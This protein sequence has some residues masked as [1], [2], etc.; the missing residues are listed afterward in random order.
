MPPVARR[1]SSG[2]A[3]GNS[4]LGLATVTLPA[5]RR[6]GLYA[7]FVLAGYLLGFTL[8]P[9]T[10]RRGDGPSGLLLD[11]GVAAGDDGGP[12]RLPTAAR[13]LFPAQLP[14]RQ[15]PA[16]PQHHS[17]LLREEGDVDL[18][19]EWG[20]AQPPPPPFPA[21]MPPANRTLR[22]DVCNGF[23]NQRLSLLYAVLYTVRLQRALVLPVLVEN[24]LQRSDA[25]ILAT[26]ANQV[27]ATVRANVAP[28]HPKPRLVNLSVTRPA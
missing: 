23:A 10:S 19:L 16:A 6:L 21:S 28:R 24:G 26:E 7:L 17:Q 8:A 11:T 15:L 13:S 27:R 5:A 12:Q 25:N 18:D 2:P 3:G 1:A 22:F 20:L 9:G 14:R 4:R